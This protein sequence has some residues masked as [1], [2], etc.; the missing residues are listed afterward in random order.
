MEAVPFIGAAPKIVKGITNASEPLLDF[1]SQ[2]YKPLRDYRLGRM[3]DDASS[4]FDGT[5]DESYFKSP[6]NWYRKTE[7]PE[8]QG[9][10]E[11]G[12]NVTTTDADYVPANIWRNHALNIRDYNDEVGGKTRFSLSKSGSAHGNTS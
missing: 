12:K 6:F 8:V 7:Y 10:R 2:L 3:V 4:K 5:V 1:A 11:M 9:I